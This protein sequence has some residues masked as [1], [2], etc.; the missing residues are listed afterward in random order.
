M[1]TTVE[2]SPAA[3]QDETAASTHQ[4]IQFLP[5]PDSEK[6]ARHAERQEWRKPLYSIKHGTQPLLTV[7][8]GTQTACLVSEQRYKPGLVA[9]HTQGEATVWS[10]VMQGSC[11][12]SQAD[13]MWCGP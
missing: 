13:H 12:R 2:K 5:L 3:P 1:S 9:S 10:L 11:L 7:L 4:H 8:R 6:V